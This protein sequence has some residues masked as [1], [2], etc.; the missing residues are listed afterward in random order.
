MEFKLIYEKTKEGGGSIGLITLHPENIDSEK[1]K[2][3]FDAINLE[4]PAKG[5]LYRREVL[6][7]YL[8]RALSLPTKYV[9]EVEN[10][11]TV[12]KR[13]KI[14]DDAKYVLTLDYALKMININER[15]ECGM[16]VIIEGETGVGKTELIKMLSK[17]WNL[18]Y[19]IDWD[20]KVTEL[21]TNLNMKCDIPSFLQQLENMEVSSLKKISREFSETPLLSLLQHK[22]HSVN[23]FWS[24][25]ENL[26]ESSFDNPK[27]F[28]EAI[29]TAEISTFHKLDVHS[30]LKPFDVMAFFDDVIKQAE[31]IKMKFASDLQIPQVTVSQTYTKSIYMTCMY[32]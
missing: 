29:L 18:G 27:A 12:F 22:H 30:G 20:E 10:G 4:I 15:K 5:D 23:D 17:L 7:K 26:N 3:L 11:E 14:I 25:L 24:F 13:L 32:M 2:P 31:S 28:L 9:T 8:A 19:V 21:Q 1:E 16:P 6:D